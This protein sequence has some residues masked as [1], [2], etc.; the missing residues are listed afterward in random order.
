MKKILFL[1]ADSADYLNI[2]VL[3]GLLNI[4]DVDLYMYP[5]SKLLFSDFKEQYSSSVRGGA[6]SI[7]FNN[8]R[9]NKI[10]E[11]YLISKIDSSYFDLI[12]LGDI[13]LS[14]IY[15]SWIENFAEKFPTKVIVL[16]G[17]DAENIFP[18]TGSVFR[19]SYKF[20]FT[21]LHKKHLYFKRELTNRSKKSMFYML[22]PDFLVKR[23]SFHKNLRKISFSFPENKI[24]DFAHLKKDKLFTKHI[25][26]DEL[27]SEID[28]AV[29]S[30]AFS[31]ESDYYGD[32]QRSKFGI[33]TKRSGWDCLRHYEIAANGAVICFKDLI[34]K[35]SKCA[36]HGLIPGKNCLSY[37][38]ARDL[39]TQINNL[40]D[41]EYSKLLEQTEVWIKSQGSKKLTEKLIK[42]AGVY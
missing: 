31:N 38:N 3:N 8:K 13:H 10:T 22:M 35:P 15:Y 19:S 26:D 29:S 42:Q 11:H 23:L 6:F 28:G 36:P 9:Q 16:D 1:G 21:R 17:S 33:T 39:M 32:I 37:K 7:F 5:E 2:S 27:L 34:K 18:Y 14:Y 24:T 12:V 41:A 20:F 40:S 30:Y 4:S 25:V